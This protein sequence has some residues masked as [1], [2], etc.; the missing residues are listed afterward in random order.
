MDLLYQQNGDDAWST[1][2]TSPTT[3][4]H[5]SAIYDTRTESILSAIVEVERELA[6]NE[7]RKSLLQQKLKKL[8]N[9]LVEPET[10]P[11]EVN[12]LSTY[13]SNTI[14]AAAP[15]FDCSDFFQPGGAN[16]TWV[17]FLD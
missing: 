3:G 16:V 14:I 6:E 10:Q 15:T 2:S 12:F 7:H 8:R 13:T 9:S 1:L 4:Q 5:L 17:F 11:A